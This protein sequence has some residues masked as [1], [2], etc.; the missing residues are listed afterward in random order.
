MCTICQDFLSFCRFTNPFT[1][2]PFPSNLTL[3]NIQKSY[4]VLVTTM[5]LVFIV[6]LTFGYNTFNLDRGRLSL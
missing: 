2:I 6:D 4:R 1:L 3:H 5:D